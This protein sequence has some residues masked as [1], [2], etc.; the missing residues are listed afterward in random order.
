M[1]LLGS[2]GRLT[3]LIS[4]LTKHRYSMKTPQHS[5]WHRLVR[6]L[7]GEYAP[8]REEDV[9]SW[10]VD[11]S[12][13]ARRMDELKRVWE[14]T[15]SD[16]TPR[17]V[18]AAL[19]AMW[20]RLSTETDRGDVEQGEQEAADGGK[21]R[22]SR[23]SQVRKSRHRGRSR[24]KYSARTAA[25]VGSV[26]ALALLWT[27]AFGSAEPDAPSAEGKTFSTAEGQRATVRLSDGS[28]VYLNVDSRLTLDK[29]FDSARRV[30]HLEG[31]AYFSV[32]PSVDRPFV[33]QSAG[34]TVEVLGTT[35]DVKA[36][37]DDDE[38]QVAVEE[39]KVTLRRSQAMPEDTVVL[40]A[41]H[42]GT[43]SGQHLQTTREGVDLARHLAWTKGKLVFDDAAFDEVVR[44]LQRWYDVRI[45]T[46]N[47]PADVDRLNATFTD[48][49]LEE[50][51]TAVAVGL[52]LQYTRRGETVAFSAGDDTALSP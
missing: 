33:V 34:A 3:L 11:D 38:T 28:E 2:L 5:D 10:I 13:R 26:M 35:F 46:E 40:E 49:S 20:D 25:I 21:R 51:L 30:V 24:W 6:Y 31:Q 8:E 7:T 16:P 41:L 50:V 1:L 19:D 43:I 44:K 29:D 22:V 12:E 52:D 45:N 39:G 48:E 27:L 37:P 14:A 36:Y 9:Q 17:D 4:L 47:V 18:D 15:R 23:R 42:L 32:T